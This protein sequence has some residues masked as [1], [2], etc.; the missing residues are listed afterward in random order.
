ME[1]LELRLFHLANVLDRRFE[2]AEDAMAQKQREELDDF[3]WQNI[4]IV[5]NRRLGCLMIINFLLSL[6]LLIMFLR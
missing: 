4:P 1:N 5:E 3:K 6:F 2:E